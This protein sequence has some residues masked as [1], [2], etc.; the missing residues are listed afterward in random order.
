[1]GQYNPIVYSKFFTL[2]Y[3]TNENAQSFDAVKNIIL[4]SDLLK[5]D[6]DDFMLKPPVLLTP[7]H[8]LCHE[9]LL[10]LIWNAKYARELFLPQR[11]AITYYKNLETNE[12]YKCSSDAQFFCVD[13]IITNC[14]NNCVKFNSFSSEDTDDLQTIVFDTDNYCVICRRALFNIINVENNGMFVC[15]DESCFE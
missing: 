7:I 14:V 3:N 13:K 1:M 11:W 8:E 4:N 5:N 10:M 9:E 12:C 15:L 2:I 6:T